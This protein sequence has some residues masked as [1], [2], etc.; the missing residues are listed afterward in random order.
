MTCLRWW[1]SNGC[2]LSL[3]AVVVALV[4]CSTTA[5]L[6]V[7]VGNDK[8]D[9]S[10]DVSVSTGAGGSGSISLIDSSLP[11]DGGVIICAADGNGCVF[12]AP[13]AGPYCGDGVVNEPSE[14]CDDGNVLPGDGCTGV[15]KKEPNFSCP[16]NGGKCLSTVRC[17]DS[18][19]TPGEACDDGNTLAGDGCSANCA[20][21][22]PGWYCP[23]VGSPCVRLVSCGDGRLQAGEACDDGNTTAGD[24]CSANCTVESGFRCTKPGSPCQ[25]V[26]VCGNRI[27][28]GAEQCDDGN[29]AAGDGCSPACR[30]EASFFDCPP[31][32][33]PCVKTVRCGD[34]KVE[35]TEQCD[36]GN[37]T[38]FDG[39]T[40]CFI[41]S[42]WRC[43]APGQ[44]CVP[45][46]GDGQKLTVEECDD[47]NP[48]SGDG[49]SST[50]R[51]EP[52]FVCPLNGQCH[53][54][55]CGDGVVEGTELCDNGAR[56]GVFT[57]DPN[58]LGCTKTCT[59]EPTCR[60]AN[61]TTHACTSRCGDGMLLASEATDAGIACDDGNLASGDGCSSTCVVEPG[62]TCSTSQVSDT[63]PCSADST[64]QCLV[65][66]IVYRDF[67][68]LEMTDGTAS[69]DF[70]YIN[71]TTR[72]SVMT[73]R[74]T[75][76]MP[77][78]VPNALCTGLVQTTLNAQGKPMLA[79]ITGNP[80]CTG[81]GM[82]NGAVRGFNTLCEANSTAMTAAAAAPAYVIFNA[83]SFSDWYL[84][85]A[86]TTNQTRFSTLELLPIAAGQF[87]ATFRNDV[88]DAGAILHN[89]GLFP[90]DGLAWGGEPAICQV[91]NATQAW[92]YWTGD[93]ATCTSAHNYHFT[94]EVRYV[95]PYQG[96]EALSFLGDDDVWVFVN[97]HLA[98]D[99]GGIHQQS[100]GSI[101]ITAANQATF[102][103]TPGNLYEIAVFHAERHPIDSN[104]QLTLSNFTRTRT[105]C[106]PTCGD[107]VATV[108]E[109]CDNGAANS[110]TLYGGCTT[111]C[112]FGARC[113]DGIT[114][115]AFGEQCDD[116][117]NTTITYGAI[118]CAPGCKL[119]P[120][121]GDGKLDPGEQ[122]D[123]GATNSDTAYGGC[124][125]T[126]TL[127]PTCGDGLV[128]RQFGEECDDGLNVGGYGQCAPG[129]KLGPRCG[130][131]LVQDGEGCD[132]GAAN[133]TPG[134]CNADCGVP[135]VC[136]DGVVQAGEDCDNGIND[137]SYGGCS[138]DC[139]F[140]PRCGD[141]VVQ[142]GS[143]E[144]CDLGRAN[145][146][147]VYGGCTTRCSYGP[148]C[149]DGILQVGVEQ[150]D[151]DNNTSF[152][153]CSAACQTELI[154][155]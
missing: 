127:G 72:P 57:G 67:H 155:K 98:V 107:G 27:V 17:G 68:G 96:G 81:L 50:C 69:P 64:Q 1:L 9:A 61:G 51:L 144:Q 24:G 126:C 141:G 114:Q 63:V 28:E 105:N 39:C 35:D 124:T 136:G 18:V 15:C 46:C 20:S 152:D 29:I 95:F 16:P 146:D 121:C 49:C 4:A 153:G 112:R 52:G 139:H 93:P 8:E 135:G 40:S 12:A 94:S 14:E 103:M 62:F 100:P 36:D 2:R 111:Q 89:G 113:G 118:G 41:D 75:V 123:D 83:A 91:R 11:R 54:T 117:Q 92:P 71:D 87:Q 60:D 99:L 77:G 149:G 150:C 128:Q 86:G 23:T 38:P 74:G 104:Y 142:T 42:G 30:K 44:K 154:V 3:W 19:R 58:N 102:G 22:E 56:N 6:T 43:P 115:T 133:G 101:T 119:P 109:E 116:G 147:G 66:P 84:D 10:A 82:N 97:G 5:E 79:A 129:C 151:D 138:V 130:D 33:G 143:G 47:G 120:R 78:C 55:V 131:G 88:S 90:L 26:P 148:H 48:T 73:V 85:R 45:N 132:E 32:G 110:D 13:D 65:L 76:Q 34:G 25:A 122:C 59:R 31:A 134:H 108:F 70:F 80:T 7:H 137:N 21:I 145:Q 53:R 140:G 125:T 37:T 106:I